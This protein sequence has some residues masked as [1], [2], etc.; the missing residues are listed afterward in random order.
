MN[1]FNVLPSDVSSGL[2]QGLLVGITDKAITK[3]QCVQNAA[4]K[5]VLKRSHYDNASRARFE[6]SLATNTG[7]NRV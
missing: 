3:M 2:Q 4:A 1:N 7:M 5:V 6:T